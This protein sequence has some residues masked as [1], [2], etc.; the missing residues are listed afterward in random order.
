MSYD[1]DN[2]FA[3]ILR[4][5]APAFKVYEDEYSLAFMDVMPQIDGHTLV[6]PKDPAEDIHTADPVILGHTIATVQRVAAAV[7]SAFAAPGIMV[8][9]LNGSAAG[10]TVFHL[11]FHVIPRL[12]GIDLA[13]HAREM[14]D[15][16][17]LAQHAERIKAE[18]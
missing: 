5:D 6:I 9:Q 3:K 12:D 8:A 18:L 7:K 13:L 10:Q 2:I 1:A 11:H 15:F 17:R 4:G 14:A 16:D